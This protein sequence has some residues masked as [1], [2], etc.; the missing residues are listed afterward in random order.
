MSLLMLLADA[1]GAVTNGI[2]QACATACNTK[3]NLGQVFA[4]V[5]NIL[6]FLVGSVSVIMIIVGG[7]RYVTSNGDSKQTEAAKNTVLYAVIGLVVAIVAYAIV[8]FVV[9]NI[10]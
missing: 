4:N 6:V 9:T 3:S 8:N 7:L 5:A 2:N 10:K 1:S